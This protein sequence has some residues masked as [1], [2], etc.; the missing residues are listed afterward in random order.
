MLHVIEHLERHRR[1]ALIVLGIVSGLLSGLAVFTVPGG[2]IYGPGLLYGL[3]VL[4]PWSWQPDGRTLPA[5]LAMAFGTIGY[6][7]AVFV[8][9]IPVL[10]SEDALVPWGLLSFA[11]A[12]TVG[13][14]FTHI[15]YFCWD[16]PRFS[17]TFMACVIWG[18]LGGMVFG[19][20]VQ[21]FIV[22]FD[23]DPMLIGLPLAFAIW[24]GGMAAVISFE[25]LGELNRSGAHDS[26]EE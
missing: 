16:K 10:L 24:Q 20:A 15:A 11:L 2:W 4:W 14:I 22:A 9:I 1:I 21:P 12:G 23:V 17:R 26:A 6:A 5:I 19:V 7:S 25:R 3:L 13:A 8:G 18:A